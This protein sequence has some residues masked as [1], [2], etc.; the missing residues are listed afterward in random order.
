[1][2]T[3][4]SGHQPGSPGMPTLHL[5]TTPVSLRVLLLM[6]TNIGLAAHLRE[7]RKPSGSGLFGR[8]AGDV[9]LYHEFLP[10]AVMT[11]E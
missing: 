5:P 2:V 8:R 6:T 9:R 1:M 11:A 7:S 4:S 3:S 10:R